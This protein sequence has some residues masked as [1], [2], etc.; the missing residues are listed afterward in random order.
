M[1]LGL[2]IRHI[3]HILE[4]VDFDLVF[5]HFMAC[6]EASLYAEAMLTIRVQKHCLP[7]SFL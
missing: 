1:K 5:E 2:V 7:L 3:T 6:L 4:T